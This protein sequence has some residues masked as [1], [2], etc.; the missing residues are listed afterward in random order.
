MRP[1]RQSRG[2]FQALI[3]VSYPPLWPHI[4]VHQINLSPRTDYV[5]LY[6]IFLLTQKWKQE[7]SLEWRSGEVDSNP[8]TSTTQLFSL[9]DWAWVP[10]ASV[11]FTTKQTQDLQNYQ[12]SQSPYNPDCM[13]FT[14]WL[15]KSVSGKHAHFPRLFQTFTPLVIHP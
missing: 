7:R 13:Q 10:W 6:G 4:A 5:M 1:C 2:K 12:P 15:P 14:S 9:Q 11:S 3:N 8:W